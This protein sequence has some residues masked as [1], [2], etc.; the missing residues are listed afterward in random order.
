MEPRQGLGVGEK[1]QVR[2]V[3]TSRLPKPRG[4]RSQARCEGTQRQ[5]F[6]RKGWQGPGLLPWG[7]PRLPPARSLLILAPSERISGL[8]P[9]W[10]LPPVPGTLSISRCHGNN[11]LADSCELG[12]DRRAN[13]TH[14]TWVQEG[15]G[16][17]PSRCSPSSQGGWS[18]GFPEP[19]WF[20][21][22]CL[23]VLRMHFF[24]FFFLLL[25]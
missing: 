2:T 9:A 17:E 22:A 10:S 25:H 14:I 8:F 12:L 21:P 3:H 6:P 4:A 7:P 11:H 1:E 18:W 24:S 16:W 20:I 5:H 15:L 13:G 19:S 23:H